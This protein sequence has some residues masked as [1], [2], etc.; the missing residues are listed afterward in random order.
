MFIQEN[1]LFTTQAEKEALLQ[2]KEKVASAFFINV[3]GTL[4][5]FSITSK[6]AAMKTHFQ[7]DGKLRLTAITDTNK[8]VSLSVLLYHEIG[9]IRRTTADK[10]TKILY[11]IKAKK[12]T[13]KNID[14]QEIRDLIGEIQ[15][16]AHRPH[17]EVLRVVKAFED[18]SLSLQQTG[19]E[20]YIVVK[21][22]KKELLSLANEFYT[23]AKQYQ[24]YF[25]NM[26]TGNSATAPVNAPLMQPATPAPTPSPVAKVQTV[27]PEVKVL[28]VREFEDRVWKAIEANYTNNSPILQ[29]L[30]RD[31]PLNAEERELLTKL[32]MPSNGTVEYEKHIMPFF[33]YQRLDVQLGNILKQVDGERWAAFVIA[34]T[35]YK[36]GLMGTSSKIMEIFGKDADLFKGYG[37][38]GVGTKRVLSKTYAEWFKMATDSVIRAA[39]IDLMG[40]AIYNI[41]NA[42]NHLAMIEMMNQR[43]S[44]TA[45]PMD[46]FKLPLK[47]AER[48]KAAIVLMTADGISSTYREDAMKILK[49]SL[50]DKAYM[51]GGVL[52]LKPAHLDSLFKDSRKYLQMATDNWSKGAKYLKTEV[53][54]SLMAD[55]IEAKFNSETRFPAIL[56]HVRQMSASIAE[57]GQALLE[58]GERFWRKHDERLALH[59]RD[60]MGQ[61]WIAH[62]GD[63][64]ILEP[65]MKHFSLQ[66][67]QK[68]AEG[69]MRPV[70]SPFRMLADHYERHESV[71]SVDMLAE[72]CR[73]LINMMRDRE[74]L[75][76][77]MLDYSFEAKYLIENF[78]FIAKEMKLALMRDT[79]N[80]RPIKLA[81]RRIFKSLAKQGHLSKELIDSA[82]KTTDIAKLLGDVLAANGPQDVLEL[83]GADEIVAAFFD[84]DNGDLWVPTP[85]QTQHKVGLALGNRYRDELNKRIPSMIENGEWRMLSGM[86]DKFTLR[87]LVL[88]EKNP[89]MIR[90][91]FSG[92]PWLML[93]IAKESTPVMDVVAQVGLIGLTQRTNDGMSQNRAVELVEWMD[94][95]QLSKAIKSSL[96]FAESLRLNLVEGSSLYDILVTMIFKLYKLDG[97]VLDQVS[98][99][100]PSDMI[101]DV[102]KSLLESKGMETIMQQVNA[103][104]NPIK[105]YE[106][107]SLKNIRDVMRYNKIKI[108]APAMSKKKTLSQNINENAAK[109][110]VLPQKLDMEELT[111]E[112]LER[113]SVE[114]D[115]FTNGRH[116]YIALKF[117]KSFHV[118]NDML[119]E[120]HEKWIEKWREKN[121][122]NPL[123]LITPMFHGCDSVAASM[124]MRYGFNIIDAQGGTVSTTGRALGNGI[125]ITNVLDKASLYVGEGY[126]ARSQRIGDKGYLM[127]M[128]AA[129][130][131]PKKDTVAASTGSVYDIHG[132]FLSPEWCVR[133]VDQLNIYKTH[134][135]IVVNKDE[136]KEL[137]TKHGMTNEGVTEIKEFKQFIDEQ[138]DTKGQ[139]ATIFIFGDGQIPTKDG[140]SVHFEKA[141]LPSYV[142]M[143]S[144]RNGPA[145]VFYGTKSDRRFIID[146][147]GEFKEGIEYRL[148]KQLM[149][150]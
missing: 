62:A 56:S 34:H 2:D 28:D 149:R 50:G 11:D 63:D 137:R 44:T 113:R 23:L 89:D 48:I 88:R 124:I 17:P 72:M 139:H 109:F 91:L 84:P 31:R 93:E 8:D 106:A 99:V 143:D 47:E 35:L 128:N 119:K 87:D 49:E 101:K 76:G 25:S 24:P 94:A 96:A 86:A 135:V 80:G 85:D 9:G 32:I 110:E 146:H 116:G 6:R 64:E 77:M 65:F 57:K 147:G 5:I 114:Y 14:V 71:Y 10:L 83:F 115:A 127:E 148:F 45:L 122:S 52:V 61:I 117:L 68:M 4:G 82:K 118:N 105:P 30:E 130:G 136:V 111:Q 54:A 81:T 20:M 41:N 90:G 140:G 97:N 79:E 121:P 138:V 19:K 69:K 126:H 145:L 60:I 66:I 39:S 150:W 100:I 15:Y 102:Y 129:L 131:I 38:V 103:D 37:F 125:Y 18:G 3:L 70:V 98:D 134:E 29:A 132:R 112:Q 42:A 67:A 1:S 7:E 55:E 33:T 73:Y 141:K 92:N 107:L 120:R 16:M 53:D 59:W 21:K 142:K 12:I 133:N 144:T 78:P 51:K 58:A 95:E 108:K 74:E 46:I 40:D 75:H 27:K 36:D 43:A 13:H 104:S 26:K 22:K 123:N